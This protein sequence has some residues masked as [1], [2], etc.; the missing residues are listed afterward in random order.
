M[1]PQL[2]ANA[3]TKVETVNIRCTE[4]TR[5][6]WKAVFTAISGDT[7]LRN[8]D[9]VYNNLSTVTPELLATAV[10]NLETVNI[11]NTRITD[12]QWK[13]VFTALCGNSKLRNLH[14]G[15]NIGG[16]YINLTSVMPGLLATALRGL[17]TVSLSG[18]RLTKEQKTIIGTLEDTKVKM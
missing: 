16:N 5:Q 2:L 13:A 17:K 14:I 8:L 11:R 1:T 6:Q 15:Y 7:K 3:V 9:I 12:Q 18:A 10:S 4:L